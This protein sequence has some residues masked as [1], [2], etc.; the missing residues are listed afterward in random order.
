[1][2]SNNKSSEQEQYTP[3]DMYRKALREASE[4][5]GRSFQEL[6]VAD[7]SN[8]KAAQQKLDKDLEKLKETVDEHGHRPPLTTA[9]IRGRIQVSDEARGHIRAAYRVLTKPGLSKE[10]LPELTEKLL[11][12]ARGYREMEPPPS[13]SKPSR[14]TDMKDRPRLTEQQKGDQIDKAQVAG[15]AQ[16][17]KHS[18]D[19]ESDSSSSVSTDSSSSD[20]ST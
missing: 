7:E 12:V 16:K 13:L 9:K 11:R 20:E 2:S 1:M 8:K 17:I 14:Y 6:K 3:I 4:A 19:E 15:Q 10:D 18:D 5:L